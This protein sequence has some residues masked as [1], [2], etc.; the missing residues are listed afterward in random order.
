MKILL[1]FNIYRRYG[2]TLALVKVTPGI[3]V[4]EEYTH[5]DSSSF[6]PMINPNSTD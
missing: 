2:K 5:F 6:L 4:L 3:Q 1:D